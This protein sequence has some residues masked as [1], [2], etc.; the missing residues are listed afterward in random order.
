VASQALAAGCKGLA[1]AAPGGLRAEGQP[2]GPQGV[3]VLLNP[4]SSCTEQ[5]S[6]ARKK[7]NSN[8]AMSIPFPKG[9]VSGRN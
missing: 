5:K 4:L 9:T 8:Q 2:Q 6:T 1:G 3:R 7:H